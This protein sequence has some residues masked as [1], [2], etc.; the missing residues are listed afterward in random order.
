MNKVIGRK[1]T[2]R[3]KV[4]FFGYFST[5]FSSCNSDGFEMVLNCVGKRVT[6]AINRRLVRPL[7][8]EE[9]KE[10]VFRMDPAK[11]PGPD[12]FA[13]SFFQNYEDVLARDIIGA[14]RSFMFSGRLLWGI[15]HT[16]IVLICKVKCSMSMG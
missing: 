6:D 12:G 10:A 7:R 5:I 9:V 1:V 14:V 11:S 4:L 16:H 3:F 2:V 13:A 8:A 15:N